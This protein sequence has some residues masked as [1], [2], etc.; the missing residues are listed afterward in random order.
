MIAIHKPS[1]VYTRGADPIN[2]V[3]NMQGNGQNG[4]AH[5]SQGNH[6]FPFGYSFAGDFHPPPSPDASLTGQ[7]L[8]RPDETKHLNKFFDMFDSGDFYNGDF[9]DIFGDAQYEQAELPPQ[10]MGST[11]SLGQ[12]PSLEAQHLTTFDFGGTN[13][14]LPSSAPTI[15]PS[16]TFTGSPTY[17]YHVPNDQSQISSNETSFHGHYSIHPKNGQHRPQSESQFTPVHSAGPL[18]GAGE[19]PRVGNFVLDL[20][21]VQFGAQNEP[22]RDRRLSQLNARGELQWGSDASFHDPERFHPAPAQKKEIADAGVRAVQA[23]KTVYPSMPGSAANTRP[24]SPLR[25]T[26][27]HQQSKQP[28]LLGISS[29]AVSDINAHIQAGEYIEDDDEMDPSALPLSI[30]THKQSKRRKGEESES[31]DPPSE[32]VGKRRKSSAAAAKATRENLTEQEKR[33]NH[34]KSEQ[35]RRTLI[36]EGFEDLSILVPGLEGGGFSKSAVLSMSADRLEELQKGNDI[37]RQRIEMIES[38][39]SEK[40]QRS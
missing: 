22:I 26:N 17:P 7:N 12:Q 15:A 28:K 16:L 31:P 25:Q 33:Q 24:P 5:G 30:Q 36:R 39:Q 4:A 32:Q 19:D 40:L 23:I 13:T 3:E 6:S 11:T 10:F 29:H 38:R 1:V 20:F 34:I 8:L 2:D 27:H 35:K 21:G 18:P 37:L 9:N 14:Y